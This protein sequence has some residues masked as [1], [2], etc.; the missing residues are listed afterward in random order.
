MRQVLMAEAPDALDPISAL[1]EHHRT[2]QRAQAVNQ[3]KA[4]STWGPPWA[5]RDGARYQCLGP[6]FSWENS[7]ETMGNHGKPTIFWY[8]LHVSWENPWFQILPYTNSI[9][10]MRFE[11]FFV[12]TKMNRYKITKA[13]RTSWQVQ[14]ESY[15]MLGGKCQKGGHVT[16]PRIWLAAKGRL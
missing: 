5:P 10:N 14:F 16:Q 1:R 13:S 9:D 6:W 11:K 2:A 3:A 15:W 8:I 7:L 4:T 12:A